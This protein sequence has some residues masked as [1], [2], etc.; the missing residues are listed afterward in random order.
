[1]L[2]DLL[3]MQALNTL[4]RSKSIRYLSSLLLTA[5]L[6]SACGSDSGSSSRGSEAVQEAS[7]PASSPNYQGYNALF[8]GH[9]FFKPVANGI[10]DHAERLGIDNH[11]QRVVF[12]GGG[13]GSPQGLWLQPDKKATIQAI[14]DAGD[15]DL[16]GMTI[17]GDYLSLEGYINWVDYALAQNPKTKFFIA[18]PWATRPATMSFDAYEA[19]N[20]EQHVLFHSEFIDALRAAY[21]DNI[22][23]G[24]PYGDAAVELYRLYEQGNLPEVDTLISRGDA[25]GIY[26]DQLGHPEALLVALS[27]LVWIQSIFNVDLSTYDYDPGYTTDLMTIASDIAARHDSAYDDQ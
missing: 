12:S 14:L 15:I 25:L 2:G 21:P 17:H 1:M 10:P 6:L 9:S 23:Y 19:L 13:T 5:L 27:E 4:F 7:P 26:K 8:I 22:F 24:I 11:T 16:F 3:T 20:N 18:L